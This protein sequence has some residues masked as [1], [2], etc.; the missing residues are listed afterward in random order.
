MER[1]AGVILHPS[2]LPNQQGIGN[3]GQSAYQ[4]V[5][6]LSNAGFKLWQ[7]CPLGPTSYGDSP[8]QC[9]SAFAGNPYF[10]DWH[11]FVELDLIES[12]ELDPLSA[13]RTDKVDYGGLFDAFGPLI[14][15]VYTNFLLKSSENEKLRKAYESF[16][17][18]N[19][20]WLYDYANFRALKEQFNN[21]SRAIWPNELSVKQKNKD[22]DFKSFISKAS[23]KHAFTQF[24]FYKQFHALKNY[25]NDKGIKL[26][27]DLPLFVAL[28]SSDVWAN[29]ELFEL[30]AQAQPINVAGV[31]PDYFSE[32]GQ[33]WG[34]PLYDW[35]AHKEDH[36]KWWKRRIKH[37]LNQ[38]DYLRIDHFRGFESYWSV[39][40]D[41]KNAINGTWKKA[42]GVELFRQLKQE[43]KSIPIIAE[44]LGIITDAVRILLN[45][46]GFPGMSVLQFAFG[47]DSK[48][49][50]LP[51]NHIKNQVVYSGTH[52]NNTSIGW[53]N[54][55]DAR[56]KTFVQRYLN[57]SGEYIGWD[58]FRSAVKSVA[59]VS[60][61]PLQDLMSLST[62]ARLNN[63][64]T[65]EGNWSWRYQQE[66]LEQLS[67]D[68]QTYI[69]ELLKLHGR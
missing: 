29:P 6:F 31:P 18:E 60:I 64:G 4:F 23:E 24:I 67:A 45:K 63:P 2:S 48:N 65:A 41:H 32:E 40:S 42:P 53:F 66:S 1:S 19:T 26:I 61:V 35:K 37:N 25:A 20:D 15:K 27:G 14:E 43:F 10:I 57:I 9:F 51:H 12:N 11:Y 16:I 34:N 69:Q 38:Y 49:S 68:S 50:Y 21:Q 39:P 28:D 17:D 13:L 47:E 22:Y 56:S 52:D 62:S 46:T 5:D 7:M 54:N 36:F 44:D 30:D 58:L 55:L 8:Y 33:L 59:Q 3:F